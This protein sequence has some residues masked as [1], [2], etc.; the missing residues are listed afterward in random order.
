MGITI[1]YRFMFRDEKALERVL[2]LVKK[3]AE[4]KLG[5]KILK[6]DMNEKTKELIIHPDGKC[7]TINLVFQRWKD[8]KEKSKNKWT[9]EY[10]VLSKYKLCFNEKTENFSDFFADD[11]WVCADFTKTQFAGAEVHAKVCEVLRLVASFASFVDISDEANYYETLDFESL[12][13]DIE[14]LGNFINILANALRDAGFDVSVGGD[15]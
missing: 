6:F 14:S 7:E 10:E 1:H 9:Y 15:V 13:K 5:M 4:E 11:D 12:V 2:F 3:F 8:V